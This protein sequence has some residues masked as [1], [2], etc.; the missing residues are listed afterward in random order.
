MSFKTEIRSLQS[1]RSFAAEW[2][3]G[4]FPKALR[5]DEPE[6]IVQRLK[7]DSVREVSPVT[8]L[9]LVAV[10]GA[11]SAGTRSSGET[12]PNPASIPPWLTIRRGDVLSRE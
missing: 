6:I 11:W 10:A 8:P 12:A 2:T 5:D 9:K 1:M 3:P 7:E 4:C